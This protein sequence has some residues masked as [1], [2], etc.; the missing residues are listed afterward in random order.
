MPVRTR[1]T[2]Q[3]LSGPWARASIH[4]RRSYARVG[5]QRCS[6]SWCLPLA[7]GGSA[8]TSRMTWFLQ[9]SARWKSNGRSASN[10]PFSRGNPN[11]TR[12]GA[13]QLRLDG[14][15]Q[16]EGRTSCSLVA[17]TPKVWRLARLVGAFRW[18]VQVKCAVRPLVAPRALR[19]FF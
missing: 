17:V 10:A 14:A 3:H 12:R 8:M 15:L 19:R 18:L 7:P 2:P 11:V 13:A 6:R 9:L 16:F 5:T 1:S 4:G